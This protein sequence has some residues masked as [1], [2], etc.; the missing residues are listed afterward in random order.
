MKYFHE[1]IET[2]WQQYW[3]Q[4]QTFAT[5]NNSEKPKY[6]VLDMFP[7]P[8]GAGLHVGHPLGYIASDIVA[9]LNVTKALMSCIHK[10]TIR[11][12]CQPNNM[13]FKQVNILIQLPKKTLRG[14]ANN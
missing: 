6:Y 14:T 11:L 2:K 3:A 4:N 7:Y 9:R 12:V 13:Q 1:Q 5:A 10:A 8:S